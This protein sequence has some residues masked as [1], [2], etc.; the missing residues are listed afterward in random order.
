MQKNN[1]SLLKKEKINCPQQSTYSVLGKYGLNILLHKANREQSGV[2]GIHHCRLRFSL[3]TPNVFRVAKLKWPCPSGLQDY[4]C[5]HLP[6]RKL[7]VC[8]KRD[9]L[10]RRDTKW[11]PEASGVK[12]LQM[13]WKEDAGTINARHRREL[14]DVL[15]LPGTLR[16][17][18]EET[19]EHPTNRKTL[20]GS[21]PKV[22]E[23]N[24]RR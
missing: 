14:L 5:Q 15:L 6:V 4:F 21:H 18:D 20:L 1:T 11:L 22:P 13:T 19:T 10:V 24:E 12:E 3:F 9:Y 7:H 23:K 8:N 17:F 16:D 2:R